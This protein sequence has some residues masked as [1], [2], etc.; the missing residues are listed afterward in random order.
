MPLAEE[1]NGAGWNLQEPVIPKEGSHVSLTG[2]SC[3]RFPFTCEAAGSYVNSSGVQVALVE[4]WNGKTWQ[5][6][7]PA[8]PKQAKTNSFSAISCV[9]KLT[10]C[11]AVGSYIDGSGAVTP[12]TEEWNGKTWTVLSP[13][14]PT[15][16]QNAVFTGVGCGIKATMMCEAVGSYS[17]SSGIQTALAE[18]YSGA[19]WQA[20][21]PNIP[22]GAKTSAFTGISCDVKLANC[23]TSGEYTSKSGTPTLFGDRLVSE[24]IWQSQSLEVPKGVEASSLNG[25]SCLSWQVCMAVGQEV[26]NGL[27]KPLM[28][29]KIGESTWSTTSPPAVLTITPNI[30]GSAIACA[31]NGECLAASNYISATGGSVAEAH[32]WS[33]STWTQH[34]PSVPKGAKITSALGAGCRSSDL[35]ACEVVGRYTNSTGRELPLAEGW[36]GKTWTV[37]EPVSPKEGQTA[38]FTAVG[39]EVKLGLCEAAGSY[40][41]ASGAKVPLAEQWNGSTWTL[42]EP[43][44]PKEGKAVGLFSV[45]CTT[46]GET[47]YCEAVGHYVNGTGTEVVLALQLKGSE[48]TVQ[49]T[50]KILLAEA[51]SLKGV[52]CVTNSNCTA[53]GS[54][55]AVEKLGKIRFAEHW[56]GTQWTGQEIPDVEVGEQGD[57]L[58]IACATSQACTAVGTQNSVPVAERWLGEEWSKQTPTVSKESEEARLTAISCAT[59]ELCLT[60]G[61][62]KDAGVEK[63]LAE[64]YEGPPEVTV[65][66]ASVKFG[67]VTSGERTV[68]YTNNGPIMWNVPSLVYTV[69]KGSKE[70]VNIK[71]GCEGQKLPSGA[72]CN[73]TL[74]YK[75]AASESYLATM[76][77]LPAPSVTVEAEA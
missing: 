4:Q 18:L 67:N 32:T 28:E 20:Q 41:N 16:G 56:D 10:A 6:Q 74:Q 76:K 45:S 38:G 53:V 35:T 30:A 39:C 60:T 9:L 19:N 55:T 66:P 52:V 7:E 29:S 72:K 14:T 42:Q 33:G 69:T 70:A 5:L 48:W 58:S 31:P 71:N 44:T 37:Q 40:T 59:L 77:L 17:N 27:T 21:T 12:L 75:V 46:A 68:E 34:S 64:L 51:S 13:L 11:Q 3:D 49:K 47:L 25:I 23:Q 1:W 61:M 36:N 22:S 50:P 57:L 15:G 63:I 2:V 26:S 43:P 54:Y 73:I 62:Y 24:K 65:L 8:T